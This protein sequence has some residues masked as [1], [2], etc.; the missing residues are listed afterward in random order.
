[1]WS[2]Q[3]ERQ[4]DAD[5]DCDGFPGDRGRSE[6]PLLHRL[7]RPLVQAE[8]SIE[9]SD[10]SNLSHSTIGQHDGIELDDTLEPRA[11]RIFR[12]ARLDGPEKSRVGC[13]AHH[14]DAAA[15]E[16]AVAGAEPRSASGSDAWPEARACAAAVAGSLRDA[17]RVG[18]PNHRARKVFETVLGGNGR[19]VE[20]LH[21][22][23]FLLQDRRLDVRR[24]RNRSHVAAA[25]LEPGRGPGRSVAAATSSA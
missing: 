25:S 10:D 15:R 13:A 21:G 22:P 4:L 1:M 3:T 7:N 23:R 17:R 6:P 18:H 19:Q 12:V 8:D 16:A 20:S 2:A 24:G 5:Q 9:R 11:H 14:P